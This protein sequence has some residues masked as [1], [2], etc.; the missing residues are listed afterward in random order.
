MGFPKPWPTEWPELEPEPRKTEEPPS[1]PAIEPDEEPV[2][3]IPELRTEFHSVTWAVVHACNLK[4]THCYDVV[5]YHRSDLDTV[6][7]HS[8]IDRLNNV[9]VD[10][11][12]FSGGELFFRK[13]LF[14]LMA[15]CKDLGMGFSARSNGTVIVEAVADRLS[16]LGISV[17][18]VS[19]DGATRETHDAVRGAGAFEAALNG[20]KSMISKGIRVQ[21]EVVLSRKNAHEAI[22]FI[23]LGEEIGVDEVN[24]STMAPRGR[25]QQRLDDLLDHNLWLSLTSILRDASKRSRVVV[26]PNCAF[27][28]PCVANIEPHITCDGWVTPC[29]LSD[30]KLFHILEA[31]DNLVRQRLFEERPKFQDICGRRAWTQAPQFR[32]E[33]KIPFTIGAA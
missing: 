8:V 1:R 26:S 21:M 10:F 4:C 13:D 14:D 24:F 28:G 3:P 17:V 30:L 7:A 16:K 20:M 29:Y 18:G 5:P 15:H 22:R 11:I 12:A 32:V 27:T 2:Y 9:G 31:P 33:E 25:A 23:E 19:F 6:G